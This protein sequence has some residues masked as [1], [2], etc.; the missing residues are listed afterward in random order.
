VYPDVETLERALTAVAGLAELV[1]PEREPELKQAIR[2]VLARYRRPDGSYA[3][4]NEYH[5]LIA[6]A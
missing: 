3:L 5:Y 4:S 6:R 1:G 2:E